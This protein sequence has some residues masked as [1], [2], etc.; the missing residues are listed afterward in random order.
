MS[1]PLVAHLRHALSV[2]DRSGRGRPYPAAIRREVIAYVS[3]QRAQGQSVALL[4]EELGLSPLTLGRWLEQPAHGAAMALF[5]PVSLAAAAPA[6]EV[7]PARSSLVVHGPGGLRIE[8]LDLDSLTQLV[9]RL[10]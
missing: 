3:R 9:R 8:G 7:L 5:R 2:A 10:A 4:A 1:S 6:V